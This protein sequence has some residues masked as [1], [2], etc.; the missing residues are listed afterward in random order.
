M[1]AGAGGTLT[2][3]VGLTVTDGESDSEG[4][5]DGDSDE[6]GGS[7][8]AGSVD[9]S[10]LGWVSGADGLC[11]SSTESDGASE[12]FGWVLSSTANAAGSIPVSLPLPGSTMS[13][14]SPAGSPVDV[15]APDR[16]RT[17][18]P[19]DAP[20]QAGSVP[21]RAAPL[22]P[23]PLSLSS[24]NHPDHLPDSAERVRTSTVPMT[25]ADGSVHVTPSK[26]NGFVSRCGKDAERSPSADAN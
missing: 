4:E 14:R 11:E 21:P 19:S 22:S 13:S 26:L 2:V 3:G 7:L 5:S 25:R 1:D 8:V 9:V 16:V 20:T 23:G 17:S 12:G 6:A 10:L 15:P 24:C 18:T